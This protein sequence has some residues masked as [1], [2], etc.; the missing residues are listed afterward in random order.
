MDSLLD[1]LAQNEGEQPGPIYKYVDLILPLPLAQLYTY[2]IPLHLRGQLR[3][4]Q[5]V[6]VPFG[7]NKLYSGLIYALRE[8]PPAHYQAKPILDILDL[9]PLVE[10]RHL[11]FWAWLA[12]YYLCT[13]GE[14]MQAALPAGL[15]LSSE[16]LLV[17]HPDC[18]VS[19][20]DF[21]AIE[22]RSALLLEQLAKLGE[23]SLAQAQEI[24]GSKHLQK[25]VQALIHQ[26]WVCLKE[27]LKQRY[28]PKTER[29]IRLAPAL[30]EDEPALR[31]AFADNQRSKRRS[32]ALIALV[33]AWRKGE[34]LSCK[35][36]YEQAGVDSS[37]LRD[38]VNRGL[39]EFYEQ[40]LSRLKSLDLEAQGNYSLSEVQRQ[41]LDELQAQYA[42]GKSV[43]LLHGVTGSG[44]TQIFVELIEQAL[45]QGRQV[46]YLLPE[47]ALTTQLVNRL[48]YHFGDKVLVYHSRFGEQERVELW[49]QG[50]QSPI[51]LGAR[52]ALFLPYRDLGLILVD[53]EHDASYKQQDP[54]PRYNARDAA[55]FLAHQHKAKV[56]L[57]TATP[58]L[59]TYQNV[60]QGKFGLVELMQRHGGLE[61]PEV[62]VVDVKEE[63]RL[64]RMKSH[65]SPQLIEAMQQTLSEGKQV[66]LFQNRRGYAPMYRCN[67]CA[68]TVQCTHC[69]VS[70]TY[71]KS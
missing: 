29:M 7:R 22:P 19:S 17:L 4:G 45:E 25:Q 24:L 16:T 64:K 53:E 44:K 38:L 47:I 6:E 8:D 70:L 50:A 21:E 63:T 65:F 59:E 52:S 58:S 40:A 46:L 26:N 28:K 36:V 12:D 57:G 60:L 54:A 39:A 68:W 35:A 9:E 11:A 56:L 66:I 61:L 2:A 10:E 48:R 49:Q 71:H 15:K 33:Q 30:T 43:V 34:A 1:F 42:G 31:Q 67:V 14:V 62:F 41:A 5:R 55:I 37:I 32:N 69:D 3:V 23:M 27:E 51:I 20:L 13:L 18:E